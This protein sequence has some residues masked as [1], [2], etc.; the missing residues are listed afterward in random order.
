MRKI[1]VTAWYC[2]S[3]P[4]NTKQLETTIQSRRRNRVSVVGAKREVGGA[5]ESKKG[6]GLSCG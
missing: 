4:W 2:Q 5:L 3:S 1:E 6:S